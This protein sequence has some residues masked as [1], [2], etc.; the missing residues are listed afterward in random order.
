[1]SAEANNSQEP[2]E[3]AKLAALTAELSN[4]EVFC[5]RV[6]IR[7]EL[8][9]QGFLLL[10]VAVVAGFLNIL[11]LNG[12]GVTEWSQLP[13]HWFSVSGSGWLITGLLRFL[14]FASVF[15]L[16]L[17]IAV[18][19]WAPLWRK[20]LYAQAHADFTARGWVAQS[21]SLGLTVYDD[22]LW[23]RKPVEVL[24][25][26]PAQKFVAK[27]WKADLRLLRRDVEDSAKS[28][29]LRLLL[30]D[31]QFQGAR[32]V[33]SLRGHYEPPEVGGFTLVGFGPLEKMPA[34]GT[35]VVVAPPD[36]AAVKN[37][38]AFQKLIYWIKD[39]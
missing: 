24:A 29:M 22:N 36:D 26:S 28:L 8:R 15:A 31:R 9:R 32:S 1:M 13:Y 21:Q 5:D 35:F 12:Q 39:L 7:D 6:L 16:V 23:I 10:A 19:V 14:S 18:S 3:Q 4:F 20:R 25:F 11:V 38:E 2:L 30:Q 27:H 37:P 17:G 33:K 34:Q